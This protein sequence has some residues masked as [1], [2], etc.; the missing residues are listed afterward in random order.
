MPRKKRDT[1]AKT[2]VEGEQNIQAVAVAE[3]ASPAT[4][5]PKEPP[6]WIDGPTAPLPGEQTAPATP[7]ERQW[8]NPYKPIFVSKDKGFEMGENRRFKQRVFLFNEKPDEQ[9]LAALKDNGFSYRA[10]EKAWTIH[11]D[12][13]TR[14]VSDELA[15][16]FAGQT[17][18]MSR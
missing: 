11:A 10:N 6:A 1:V 2:T 12:P 18:S 9:V 13:A 7:E 5:E 17:A 14:R 15:R 4:L 16:A 8:G 3:P